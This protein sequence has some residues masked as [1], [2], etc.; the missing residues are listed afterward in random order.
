[1]ETEWALGSREDEAGLRQGPLCQTQAALR[2]RGETEKRSRAGDPPAGG[3]ILVHRLGRAARRARRRSSDRPCDG[4]HANQGS[5]RGA[6]E[7]RSAMSRP[8]FG[9]AFF[10]CL[11]AS[12]VVGACLGEAHLSQQV[13]EE[14]L[15]Q[16]PSSPGRVKLR[17][18]VTE[19]ANFGQPGDHVANDV[20]GK[21]A[22]AALRN[23]LAS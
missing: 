2:Q 16:V 20:V 9:G 6:V 8:L 3:E 13:A 10:I 18:A 23:C 17:G 15:G 11:L 21:T 1:T 14:L 12:L 19:D 5:A 22:C 4:V 7:F